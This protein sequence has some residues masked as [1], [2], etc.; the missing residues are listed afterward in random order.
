MALAHEPANTL[1]PSLVSVRQHDAEFL[2]KVHPLIAR[3]RDRCLLQGPVVRMDTLD[4]TLD[5][6]GRVAG[7]VA[8]EAIVRRGSA[9][10]SRTDI[11]LPRPDTAR[12]QRLEH[13]RIAVDDG[14]APLRTPMNRRLLS[15]GVAF[16][17]TRSHCAFLITGRVHL[18][19]RS[20]AGQRVQNERDMGRVGKGGIPPRYCKNRP[21]RRA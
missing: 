21:A 15:R 2:P 14:L 19:R 10:P 17:D 12:V 16:S 5:G 7:W 1:D 13:A 20:R 18:G 4:G 8:E 11:P 3:L 6:A 9:E